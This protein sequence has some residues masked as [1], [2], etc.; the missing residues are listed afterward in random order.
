LSK[1]IAW[2]YWILKQ[3]TPNNIFCVD[4][5]SRVNT[6]THR[7]GHFFPTSLCA[8]S[9]CVCCLRLE[10][11]DKQKVGTCNR[12]DTLCLGV[13]VSVHV[14]E[15]FHTEPYNIEIVKIDTLDGSFVLISSKAFDWKQV[16]NISLTFSLCLASFYIHIRNLCAI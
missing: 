5:G 2:L 15:G 14:C 16:R 1:T 7:S 3:C 9:S 13:C 11:Y 8:L 4:I 12:K 10:K 6:H